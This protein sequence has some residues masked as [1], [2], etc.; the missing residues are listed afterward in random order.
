MN[1]RKTL[2]LAFSMFV[3]LV[4]STGQL[5]AQAP[6]SSFEELQASQTLKEKESVE[7][8]DETGTTF[9]ASLASISG[10]TITFTREGVQRSLEE[11]QI[12][13]IRHER[14][15]GLG[16]GIG[17][18]ILAGLGAAA[19]T[20][21]TQCSDRECLTIA[22]A[23]FFP[24]FAGIGAGA[25]ALIDFAIRKQDTV[26]ARRGSSAN[27]GMRIAPIVGRKTAGVGVTFEF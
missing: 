25:G 19:L 10:R 2:G 23:V 4:G 26:F 22:S 13:K 21:G 18:G 12:L 17:V 7:I 15:D 1:S 14:R 6:A 8:T 3:L 20:V 16:N 27:H 24:T 5:R 9:R 11:S